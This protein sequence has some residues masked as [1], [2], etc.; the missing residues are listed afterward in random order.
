ME[1]LLGYLEVNS[2]KEAVSLLRQPL[3]YS[4][5]FMHTLGYLVY[6]DRVFL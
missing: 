1:S 3:F 6:I 5:Y 2:K 4:A